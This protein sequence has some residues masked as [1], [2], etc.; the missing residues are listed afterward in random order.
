MRRAMQTLLVAGMVGTGV[1]MTSRAAAADTSAEY[2]RGMTELL[3]EVAA[4]RADTTALVQATATKPE[5]ACGA[6]LATLAA[7]GRSVAADLAG[8]GELAPNGLRARHAELTDAMRVMAEA[9]R[10]ACA[11]SATARATMV[12]QQD[13]LDNAQAPIR[14]FVTGF[15]IERPGLLPVAGTGN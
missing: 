1:W 12:T 9:A 13:R 15:H 11:D 6:E 4:W 14:A 3:P 5:L 10:T 2:R 8:T 7:L